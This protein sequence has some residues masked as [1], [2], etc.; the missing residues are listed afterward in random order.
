MIPV[1]KYFSPKTLRVTDPRSGVSPKT[2]RVTDPRSGVSWRDL[3]TAR[4]W[5]TEIAGLLL[6]AAALA[7]LLIFL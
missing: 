4:E 3:G 1:G 5:I 2:L 7:L 6:C